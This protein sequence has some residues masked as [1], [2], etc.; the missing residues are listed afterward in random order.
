MRLRSIRWVVEDL[1]AM[2]KCA[3]WLQANNYRAVPTRG[4]VWIITEHP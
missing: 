3:Q 2:A 4:S 1:C